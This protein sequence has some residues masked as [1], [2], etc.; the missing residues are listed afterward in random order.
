MSPQ[1]VGVFCGEAAV[2]SAGNA[3]VASI[4]SSSSLNYSLGT[5]YKISPTGTLLWK[6]PLQGVPDGAV[7]LVTTPGNQSLVIVADQFPEVEAFNQATGASVWDYVGSAA[8]VASPALSPDGERPA[9]T[10][11]TQTPHVRPEHGYGRPADFLQHD[12]QVNHCRDESVACGGCA[13]E[14][15]PVGRHRRLTGVFTHGCDTLDGAQ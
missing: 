4:D 9:S 12:R 15:L 13:G 10:N 7:T 8:F 2:D 6:K 1:T 14:C 11:P 5:L 3:Y